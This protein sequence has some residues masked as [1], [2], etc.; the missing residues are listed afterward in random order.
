M[1]TK[2]LYVVRA[3]PSDRIFE[4]PA[5]INR[6]MPVPGTDSDAFQA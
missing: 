1:E 4:V 3:D 2:N 5:M 6:L